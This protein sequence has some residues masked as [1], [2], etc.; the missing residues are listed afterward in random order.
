MEDT[1]TI[2][3]IPALQAQELQKDLFPDAPDAQ[4]Q[5]TVNVVVAAPEGRSLRDPGVRRPGGPLVAELQALPQMPAEPRLANPVQ[6]SRGAVPPGG[7]GS[8]RGRPAACR[9]RGER[10]GAAPAERGRPRRHHHLELRRGLGR[11]RRAR[12]P[13][14]AARRPGAGPHRRPDR[15]G[16]RLRPAGRSP[17]SAAPASWSAS[18][19]RA[20]VL[21]I[22]F[23]SLVAAGLPILDRPGRRRPRHPRHQHRHGA[24]HH[25][26]HDSDPGHDDR[27]GGRHRLH[28]VHPRPLPHRA[29][30]HRRPAR[31]GRHR[32]RHRGLGGR[33][34]RA[35]PC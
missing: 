19:W 12:D 29:A 33:L 22:T 23:G 34:R 1:F 6:A 15:R 18:P 20:V 11:R 3:G 28:A 31:G 30:P 26:H 16:Q 25:R 13:R 14:G 8:R 10:R 4:D 5:A 35:S 24:D 7:P 27:P 17:R 21:V 32:G 2:P 9:R